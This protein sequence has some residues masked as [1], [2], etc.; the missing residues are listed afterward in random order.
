MTR[1]VVIALTLAV[2]MLVGLTADASA[3]FGVHRLHAQPRLHKASTTPAPTIT[4]VTPL[5]ANV[6]Q[7]LTILGKNFRL[8]KNK[9]RVFFLRQ[10]GGVA[11]ASAEFV[12]KTRLVVTIPTTVTTLLR[13]GGTSTTRTRFQLRILTTLYGTPTKMAKSPL[14]GAASTNT[15]GGGPVAID[16]PNGDC[17]HDGVKNKDQTDDDGDLVADTTEVVTTHTDPCKSDT[18]GDTVTDGYEWQSAKDLNDTVHFGVPDAA[19]PYP[20]KRPWP[21]PLDPTDG[22]TDFD[23]DGLTMIDEYQLFKFYGHNTMPLN[24]SDGKQ[25]SAIVPAP[26]SLVL[27]YM[28]HG[29]GFLQDDERDAD[30]DGLGNWDEKYGRMTAKF[31]DDLMSGQGGFTKETHYYM[32]DGSGAILSFPGTSHVDPDTDGDGVNDGADD[33]DHDGLSNAFEISRPWD[34]MFTYVSSAHSG[35]Q[36]EDYETP[37]NPNGVPAGVGPN[38]FARVQPYNPC[39]PIYSATCHRHPA[40][41]YYGDKEDWI[42]QPAE[43]V[44]PQPLAPWLYDLADKPDANGE[45]RAVPP[46]VVVTP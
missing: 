38:P 10:G 30:G 45:G 24:Y 31:W 23:G 41:G 5:K 33:Q 13:G 28:D 12:T 26:T 43:I 35:P 44:G 15:P 18:D 8:G 39:K 21:N 16:S 14:I 32:R 2:S 7:K 1:R 36:P 25:T 3:R 29:D 37:E 46:P 4:S 27:D 19:L 40:F 42:G 17:N 34:W 22:G 11:S 6:G 20:G 9:T